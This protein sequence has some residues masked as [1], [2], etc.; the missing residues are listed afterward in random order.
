MSTK[1]Y[2]HRTDGESQEGP[3]SREEVLSKIKA[4]PQLEHYVWRP[5]FGDRWMYAWEVEDLKEFG[6]LDI[7]KAAPLSV[8]PK[9][10]GIAAVCLIFGFFLFTFF[11]YL[12]VEAKEP[13]AF[14]TF[15]IIGSILFLLV[16]WITIAAIA[17]TV[18][19]E[20]VNNQKHF[21]IRELTAFI[22]KNLVTI[23]LYVPIFL[24]FIVGLL[25]AQSLVDLVGSIAGVGPLFFGIA[26]L[27]P[28]V[29]SFLA[30]VVILDT[31][32]V[33]P[34]YVAVEEK[35]PGNM[36]KDMFNLMRRRGFYVLLCETVSA[37]INGALTLVLAIN[38]FL[39]LFVTFLLAGLIMGSNFWN[40]MNVILLEPLVA[41]VSEFV[42]QLQQWLQSVE[43]SQSW[44]YDVGAFFLLVN[45][46]LIFAATFTYSTVYA[47]AAG[48]MTYLSAR[49]K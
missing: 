7:L 42:P 24:L 28:F 38:V 17:R 1:I 32:F 11:L 23:L 15:V 14:R 16:W 25:A 48:V 46:I 44:V 19:L 13:G 20:V 35:S 49:E 33:F 18:K 10:I 3:L 6:F 34:A 41:F 31:F 39:S 5:D 22:S 43:V 36:I 8:N 47:T 9:R 30:I 29:L 2:Y 26:F 4:S 21:P 40:L 12:G 45:L 27:L 37:S